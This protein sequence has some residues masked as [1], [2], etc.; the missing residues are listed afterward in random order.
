MSVAFLIEDKIAGSTAPSTTPWTLHLASERVTVRELIRRRVSEEVNAFNG[1]ND[2]VFHGL[3]QPGRSERIL[4]GYRL[5]EKRVLDVEE[6]IETALAAF[7][8]NGFF[9]LFADRQLVD[10]DEEITI[11][12]NSTVTFYRLIPLVGG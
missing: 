12:E 5:A 2:L 3:V 4:N 8:R 11:G 10:L 9:I 7:E 1:K 6:Q